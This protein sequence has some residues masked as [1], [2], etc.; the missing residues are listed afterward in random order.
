MQQR[1]FA[2]HRSSLRRRNIR[3]ASSLRSSPPTSATV[4]NITNITSFATTRFARRRRHTKR[5]ATKRIDPKIN[6][7]AL[8]PLEFTSPLY[9]PPVNTAVEADSDVISRTSPIEGTVAE[10]QVAEQSTPMK[11]RRISTC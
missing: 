3:S 6:K 7:T 4:T 5:P 11:K 9:G 10:I 2:F 8:P 1:C